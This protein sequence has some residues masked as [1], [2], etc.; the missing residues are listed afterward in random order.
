MPEQDKFDWAGKV[1]RRDIQRLYQS[2]AGGLLDETL[3]DQ[4]MYAI[5]ARVLDTFEVRE[6]QQTG[7]ARCRSCGAPIPQPYW[8]G[9][10]NKN[11]TMV[12]GQCGW[13]VTCGEYFKSYTGKDMLPGSRSELF[14]EFLER[15]AKAS[16]PPE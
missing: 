7:R 4:V 8:M 16:T 13:Q 3:L 1:S 10:R 15:F 5:H 11:V 6:A 9:G 12:C 14:Q 2:G